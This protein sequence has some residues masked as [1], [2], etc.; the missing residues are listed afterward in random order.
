MVPIPAESIFIEIPHTLGCRTW[1]RLKP[2][3]SLVSVAARR[4]AFM[5]CSPNCDSDL[6]RQSVENEV[7]VPLMM[8]TDY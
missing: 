8:V 7:A 1:R 5:I 4:P 6:R 3:D 2:A